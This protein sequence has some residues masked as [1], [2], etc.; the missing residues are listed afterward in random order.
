[1]IINATVPGAGC[2][3]HSSSSDSETRGP[4]PAAARPAHIPGVAAALGLTW[5]RGLVTAA[6]TSV[7][8][9]ARS[10]C[11]NSRDSCPGPGP[12]GRR[13]P[14]PE[15]LLV[16]EAACDLRTNTEHCLTR[17]FWFFPTGKGVD[18]RRGSAGPPPR[19]RTASVSVRKKRTPEERCLHFGS[20]GAVQEG[21]DRAPPCCACGARLG[22]AVGSRSPV[23]D[24]PRGAQRPTCHA[25]ELCDRNPVPTRK[26]TRRRTV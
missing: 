5:A 14:S 21:Q 8:S 10:L 23:S 24:G 11:R 2:R 6:A 12:G 26:H 1:M 19:Y 9:S 17:C 25:A 15:S 4:F 16:R 18:T 20:P 7:H 22:P 13:C 3:G